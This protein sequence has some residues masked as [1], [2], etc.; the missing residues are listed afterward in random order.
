MLIV[1]R[2]AYKNSSYGSILNPRNVQPSDMMKFC[3]YSCSPTPWHHLKTMKTF[4]H[5]NTVWEHDLARGEV[6]QDQ[7]YPLVNLDKAHVEILAWK[8]ALGPLRSGPLVCRKPCHESRPSSIL[9]LTR[10]F[11]PSSTLVLETFKSD[12]K[13]IIIIIIAHIF[14]HV[15]SCNPRKFMMKQHI[16]THLFFSL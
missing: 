14:T 11:C 9:K 6:Q 15:S 3:M 2:L 7:T 8:G 4:I 10:G 5:T 12:N 13:I 16:M 1:I